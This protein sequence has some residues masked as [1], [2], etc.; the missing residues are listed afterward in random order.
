MTT[1]EL[2][3][4]LIDAI[5]EKTSE[6]GIANLLMGI[7]YIGKEAIYRRLRN[8]VPFTF[9]EAVR[10]AQK[11][12]ISLDRLSKKELGQ[13]VC[14]DFGIQENSDY[15]QAYYNNILYFT[16]AV[17]LI[18]KDE[19]SEHFS[20]T[21]S[22]PPPF[23]M[24]YK[25]LSKFLIFKWIYH[26][27]RATQYKCL[28]D[29]I[30]PSKLTDIQEKLAME[31]RFFNTTYYV[32]DRAIFNTLIN[33]IRYFEEIKLLS[34]ENVALL[35]QEL[36]QMLDKLEECATRGKFSTGKS[37][38]IYISNIHF[39]ATYSYMRSQQ[40][41]FC[42]IEIYGI[43]S[44]TSRDMKLYEQIKNWIHASKKFTT[45]ISES[46]GIERIHFFNTQRNNIKSL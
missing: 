9:D 24:Q 38:N 41:Q 13:S 1:E 39:D 34:K 27:E 12:G 18:N 37:V 45:L 46:G 23:Y 31:T 30:I 42:L 5:K 4:K 43:N 2:N 15:L 19:G 44:L 8:E 17:T 6:R 14:L 40:H 21:N 29:L 35:K 7:L 11:L 20:A 28:D 36:L 33:D 32:W 25:T 22:I 16:E 10:V 26:S 3:Q